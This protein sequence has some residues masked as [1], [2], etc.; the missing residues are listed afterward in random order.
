MLLAGV[1][2]GLL[3][4][5]VVASSWARKTR[6]EE[7]R[8]RAELLAAQARRAAAVRDK[9]RALQAAQRQKK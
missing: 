5:V 3:T 9:V 7:D 2:L 4:L 6:A 8:L 1:V